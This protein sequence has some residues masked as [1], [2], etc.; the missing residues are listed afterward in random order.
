MQCSAAPCT[1]PLSILP[2]Q[3]RG[4][5]LLQ[6]E[7]AGGAQPQLDLAQGGQHLPAHLHL[8]PHLGRQ[9]RQVTRQLVTCFRLQDWPACACAAITFL[10][11]CTTCTF[12]PII[13][14]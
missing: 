13:R 2:V 9:V 10:Y 8:P 6:Q 4:G 1:L 7:A 5:E 14:W 3:L 11:S 12:S